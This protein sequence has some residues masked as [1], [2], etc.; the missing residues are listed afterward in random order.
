MALTLTYCD[1]D[2][3]AYGLA[4]MT[5]SLA[6]LDAI[7]RVVS[8]S[9]DSD[10]PM[11]D[12]S[13]DYYFSLSPA[14]SPKAVWDNML[15]N[16]HITASMVIGNIMARSLVRLREEA[17]ADV[18]EKIYH[19]IEAEGIDTCGLEE[20]EIKAIYNKILLQSRRIFMNPRLHPAV[21]SLAGIIARRRSLTGGELRDQL[22]YLQL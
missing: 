4:G 10:G 11:V 7:D 16:Y 14:I 6:S 13:H 21:T 20:D 8:V 18:M 3:R 22:N 17:P 9:L 2:D 19:E 15:R 5:I 1:E 12:F